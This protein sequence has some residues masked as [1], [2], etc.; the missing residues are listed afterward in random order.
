MWIGQEIWTT[1][2]LQVVMYFYSMIM[3]FHG[4]PGNS[5][6]LLHHLLRLSIKLSRMQQKKLFGFAPSSKRSTSSKKLQQTFNKTINRRLLFHTT[7]QITV[8]QSTLT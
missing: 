7:Q 6:Q 5:Q 2:S 4:N 8:E 3:S 1:E